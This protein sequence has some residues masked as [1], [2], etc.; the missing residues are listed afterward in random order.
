MA[1]LLSDL[2]QR[3][4]LLD[5]WPLA[6]TARGPSSQHHGATRG[7]FDPMLGATDVL[8]HED[9]WEF[10]VDVPGIA[11]NDLNLEV[12]DNTLTIRGERKH[13]YGNAR[14]H[15]PV[16]QDKRVKKQQQQQQPQQQ[17]QEQ[18][19]L[20]HGDGDNDVD[21]TEPRIEVHRVERAFGAFARSFKLPQ[22]VDTS[23]ITASS[24]AGVLSIKVPKVKPAEP[25][26]I[27][28]SMGNSGQGKLENKDSH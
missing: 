23:A 13:T 20:Q 15:N 16:K 14:P 4:P 2:F 12:L 19:E 5:Y 11:D 6:V 8:E 22:H 27:Q 24:T 3:D 18:Q 10:R 17:K 7:T 9:H 1:M 25:V 21:M 26:R 28:I